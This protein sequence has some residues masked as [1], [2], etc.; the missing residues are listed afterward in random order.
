[1]KFGFEGSLFSEDEAFVEQVKEP[2]LL[3]ELAA[4]LGLGYVETRHNS[5]PKTQC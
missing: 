1:M 3:K 2:T 4:V 5:F